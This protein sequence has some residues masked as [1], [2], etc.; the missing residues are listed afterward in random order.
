MLKAGEIIST[1][2]L[3]TNASP[4]IIHTNNIKTKQIIFVKR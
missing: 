1:G 2:Y 3:V 4:E